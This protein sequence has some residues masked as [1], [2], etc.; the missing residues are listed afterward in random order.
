MFFQFA[1]DV[2][3]ELS[4]SFWDVLNLD[5]LNIFGI[6]FSSF[7]FLCVI[8]HFCV[9]EDFDVNKYFYGKVPHL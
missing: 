1:H 8:S 7:F 5:F 9:Q 3:F 6:F 2:P 4:V